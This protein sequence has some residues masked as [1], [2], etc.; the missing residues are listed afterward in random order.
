MRSKVIVSLALAASMIAVGSASAYE[1]GGYRGGYG[2]YHEHR[3]NGVNAGVA[4]VGG[5][6]VGALVANANNQPQTIPQ[7]QYSPAPPPQYY[8]QPQYY[9]APPAPQYQQPQI[10]YIQQAPQEEEEEVEYRPMP[11]QY[12]RPQPAPQQYQPAPRYYQ[13]PAELYEQSPY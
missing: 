6:L 11:P 9:Q 7:S 8:Q 12:Y 13:G 2:G 1:H 4:L 5:L 3:G 10:I